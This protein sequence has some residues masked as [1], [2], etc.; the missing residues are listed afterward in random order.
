MLKFMTRLFDDLGLVQEEKDDHSFILRHGDSML[1][2]IP[3]IPEEGMEITYKRSTATRFE[4]L[5]FLSG[6]SELVTHCI[7][8]VLTDVKGKASICFV[9]HEDTPVGAFWIEIIAVLNP[10]AEARLQLYQFLPPT[11]IKICVDAKNQACDMQFDPIFKVKP[12]VAQ[13]L[14]AALQTQI[15]EGISAALLLANTTLEEIKQNALSDIKAKLGGEI[16]RLSTLQKS[17][18]AIRDEEIAYIAEQKEQLEQIVATAEPSLDS[19]R[20]VVN[21]RR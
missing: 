1:Y 14:I 6:D 17:N 18:P 2:P 13:Q 21:N 7:D 3:G 10:S 19:V 9:N 11:P 8:S 5:A 16:E 15:N 4:H 20:V 12:K